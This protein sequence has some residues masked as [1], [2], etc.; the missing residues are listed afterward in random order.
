MIFLSATQ[1][2]EMG[3]SRVSK[4]NDHKTNCCVK[5][6]SLA[7]VCAK[8]YAYFYQKLSIVAIL[9]F[10]WLTFI[11]IEIS[12]AWQ[13]RLTP[14]LPP[15]SGRRSPLFLSSVD[16]L[17]DLKYILFLDIFFFCKLVISKIHAFFL[18][19]IMIVQILVV[20]Q[21][22]IFESLG[23]SYFL[24]SPTETQ[25]EVTHVTAD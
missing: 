20:Q 2:N 22:C 4:T 14:L 6:S 24:E 23:K 11:T 19:K 3:K 21:N 25:L 1:Q 12:S 7:M 9:C 5:N 18:G 15:G 10:F 16:Q 8:F 17:F 13:A